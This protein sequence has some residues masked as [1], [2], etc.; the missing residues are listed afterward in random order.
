[1]EAM[2]NGLAPAEGDP[3]GGE[4]VVVVRIGSLAGAFL[5]GKRRACGRASPKGRESET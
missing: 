5:P 2:G 3:R 1:M 4:N